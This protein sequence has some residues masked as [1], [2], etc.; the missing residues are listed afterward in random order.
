MYLLIN[1]VSLESNYTVACNLIKMH[2]VRTQNCICSVII[3]DK[4][5]TNHY[6]ILFVPLEGNIFVLGLIAAVM[7]AI[8]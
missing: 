3:E 6:S 8:H 2:V 5:T 4:I 7:L 1:F